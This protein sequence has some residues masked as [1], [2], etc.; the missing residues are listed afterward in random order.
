MCVVGREHNRLLV[1]AGGAMEQTSSPEVY[2]LEG[3]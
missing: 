1:M 2:S 3:G